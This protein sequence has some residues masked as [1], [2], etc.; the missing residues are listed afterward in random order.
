M[1]NIYNYTV[2]LYFKHD[3]TKQFS[4]Y[5]SVGFTMRLNQASLFGCEKLQ[6]FWE[7]TF[8]DD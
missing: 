7:D 8:S 4:S 3:N 5:N 1:K 2:D 6:T